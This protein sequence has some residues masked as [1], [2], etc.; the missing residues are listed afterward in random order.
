[1][2][3]VMR[4]FFF[5]LFSFASSHGTLSFPP[6]LLFSCS[7]HHHLFLFLKILK[8]I[9]KKKTGIAGSKKDEIGEIAAV[10]L[11][12]FCVSMYNNKKKK[13]GKIMIY[14]SGIH[15]LNIPC[16]LDTCG[17]WHSSA[18][19]WKD[20]D[21][22]DSSKSIFGDYG[23]EPGHKIPR[24]DGIYNVANTIRALL[25]LI[26][27]GNFAQAQGMNDDFISNPV[28]D[29]EVFEK[30]HLL[31]SR[32]NWDKISAFMGKEYKMK[33]LRFLKEEENHAGK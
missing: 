10:W 11:Q 24:H 15:A 20:I 5:F 14:I 1:M 29:E 21:I 17:D 13:G 27:D 2:K 7:L 31:R 33:W 3:I 26:D 22:R 25:D 30:V 23:I 16:S 9:K 6:H 12:L 28:Y 19:R 8:E 32:D 4:R 18:L